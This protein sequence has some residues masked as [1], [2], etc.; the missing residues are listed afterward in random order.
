MDTGGNTASD[1]FPR[2]PQKL[3]G[4]GTLA[5]RD[6]TFSAASHHII[7]LAAGTRIAEHPAPSARAVLQLTSR[8]ES[9]LVVDAAALYGSPAVLMISAST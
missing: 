9:S 7:K 4:K 6:L 3:T 8:A 1:P 2:V 5:Y